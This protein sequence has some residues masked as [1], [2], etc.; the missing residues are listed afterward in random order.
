MIPEAVT[1]VAVAIADEADQELIVIITM[2]NTMN[3][4]D[5]KIKATGRRPRKT[6]PITQTTM[7][8]EA[9]EEGVL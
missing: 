3:S 7:D 9:S 5:T 8:I 6:T 2:T 4:T 1:E